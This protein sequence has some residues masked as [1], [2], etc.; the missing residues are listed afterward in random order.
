MSYDLAMRINAHFSGLGPLAAF[1]KPWSKSWNSHWLAER[2]A[3]VRCAFARGDNVCTQKLNII[4]W[5]IRANGASRAT[6]VLGT[7]VDAGC[8]HANSQNGRN[9]GT[10]CLSWA[11]EVGV[12]R[13][14]L[15][16]IT[17]TPRTSP[18]LCWYWWVMLWCLRMFPGSSRYW[19]TVIEKCCPSLM[20][21][22]TT[23][24]K[25]KR[26]FSWH[27]PFPG[28]SWMPPS[29]SFWWAFFNSPTIIWGHRRKVQS[30]LSY[31]NSSGKL[32]SGKEEFA[33]KEEVVFVKL[34][35]K[36]MSLQYEV[37]SLCYWP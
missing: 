7:C 22:F 17:D 12:W 25:R 1:C 6:S 33:R 24:A 14:L 8:L 3:E 20:Y 36:Q 21:I 2:E 18:T 32:T 10:L 15:A 19:Y 37:I 29:S 11:W 31:L 4:S 34:N 26:F 35:K 23:P 13:A 16:Q 28:A 27:M 5:V 30:L 9:P